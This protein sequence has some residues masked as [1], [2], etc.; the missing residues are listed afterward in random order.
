TCVSDISCYVKT[1][2]HDVDQ[3]AAFFVHLASI[4]PLLRQG[5]EYNGVPIDRGAPGHDAEQR[6]FAA[7]KHVRQNVRESFWIAGHFQGNVKT[8]FHAK[9]VHRVADF[10]RSHIQRDISSHLAR[11]IEAIRVH[12]CDHDVTRAGT[13]ADRNGHATDRSCASDEH[14]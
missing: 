7:V 1:V 6:H 13:F 10:F 12:V 3:I 9:L 5:P 14:I 4:N 2:H 8:F 11:E